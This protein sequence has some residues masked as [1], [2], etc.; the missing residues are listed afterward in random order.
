MSRCRSRWGLFLFLSLAAGSS[1]HAQAR[2]KAALKPFPLA[3]NQYIVILQDAP[4]A[5]RF[6]GAGQVR[7][8]SATAYRQQ[9]QAQQQNVIRDL[10]F[11]NFR[12]TGSVSTILN[13]VFVSAAAS[14][15]N[16][17]KRLPGVADVRP[18]RRGRRHVNRA[19]QLANAPS[20]WNA[21][22]G[23]SNAGAGLK[24]AILDSGIDQ[25]H[26]AFQ[27]SSLSVP[28]GFPK[29]NVISDCQ[30]FTNSKVI[31]ARSYVSQIASG[32]DP[33]NPAADSSP[34]DYSARDREGHGTA[35]ASVAAGNSSAGSVPVIGMAPKAWLGSY[36]IYG[37][38][39][40]NDY[41][42]ETVW[43]SAIE[44]AV[45]DGMDVAIFS[46]GLPAFSG[47]LDTGA[48]CGLSGTVPCDPLATA[49]ENAAK[50][51]V[52]IVASAGNDGESGWIQYPNFGSI[53][54]PAYAP[55][56]L[57]VGATTSSHVLTPTVSIADAGAP[58]NLKN[59]PAVL[60]DSYS[61]LYYGSVAVVE[62]API[63]DVSQ[64]GNDGLACASL[65]GGS[66]SGAYALIQRGTCSFTIKAANAA[67][68]GATGVIF[69]MDDGSAPVTPTQVDQFAGNVLMVSNTDGV[70]LKS[71]LSSNSGRLITADLAGAELDIAAYS[72]S[73]GLNPAL[74]ANQFASYSSMGPSTG[75]ES[76]IK[77]DLVATGGLDVDLFLR[78]DWLD[79]NLPAA[80]GMYLA[81][82]HFDQM[83]SLYSENGYA[84]A[85]GTS[86][87]APLV[88]GSAALV[89]QAHPNYSA[90][91]IRSALVN[92]TAQ[93]V[94]VDDFGGMVDVQWIGAGR[95]D[96]GAAT[97]ATVT[98]LPT[99]LSFGSLKSTTTLPKT[100]QIVLV[101]HASAPVTLAAAVSAAKAVAGTSVSLDRPSIALGAATASGVCPA[102][103]S[104]R[105][106]VNASLTGAVPG[107]GT[108]TG[109][110]TL[111]G[112]GVSLRL[113]Y[114]FLVGTGT[115]YNIPTILGSSDGFAG[116]DAGYWAVAVND[117]VGLPV[118]GSPVTL[119]VSPRGSITFNSVNGEPACTP[120]TSSSTISCPTDAF[121]FAW[122]DLVLG[123]AGAPTITVTAA[124]TRIPLSMV[125]RQQPTIPEGGVLPAAYVDQGTAIVPGSYV[126]IYGSGL[127]DYVLQNPYTTVPLT[128]AGV[129]VSFDVP[130]AGISVPGRMVYISPNQVNVQVPWE[131]QGQSSVKTKVTLN[132]YEYGNVVT[133]PVSDYGPAFFHAAADALDESYKT[134]TAGNPVQRG[135]VA[136]LFLNGLGP[137]NNQPESGAPASGTLLATTKTTPIVMIGG[138]PA[139]VQFSGLAPGFP[140]LYQVNAVVPDSVAPGNTVPVTV[141]IGG[142]TSKAAT[143]AVQ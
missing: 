38:P 101:N 77:P 48:V 1:A 100:I 37:S 9:I 19:I 105:A 76:A 91:E 93:D 3:G 14:R 139:V 127:S 79:Q 65:P 71:Y 116:Q 6:S 124:G 80:P 141:A 62:T 108:Y 28:N 49:F 2:R 39:G 111:Q 16:E 113:P 53:S 106:A 97:A 29:C 84:A 68:A 131:L 59:I 96:A 12:I 99:T 112:T 55:S 81:A 123:N 117:A 88:G 107:P 115:P 17:L 34:D 78:P 11:R 31:V 15:L 92:T 121:G 57:A 63:T 110:V 51:G 54:S 74:A 69:Y 98:A 21:I 45:K 36:K 61:T 26:P 42:P 135:H 46:S 24:I 73:L 18:V 35:V 33:A 25:T 85:D 114:L 126:A 58:S 52:V 7:T 90:D 118:E 50:S 43:I 10:T 44:D 27:D 104:C 120:A 70:A 86:F 109:M 122:V 72:A 23:Q 64:L 128:L 95:L 22:G 13:A 30:N 75:K 32:S 129:T 56:V 89:K 136:Q 5:A 134:I 20:A 103:G 94:T 143:L 4:V 8:A 41:P 130:S 142:Q 83:G 132:E 67:N 138:A 82:Q 47:P 87:S 119:S 137:V 140:G 40:V 102:N 66:L 60:G 133:V 125:V